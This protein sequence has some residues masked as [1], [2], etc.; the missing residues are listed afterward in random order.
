MILV[1]T[2]VG[3]MSTA[4]KPGLCSVVKEQTVS[5]CVTYVIA[6]LR[7]HHDL[8]YRIF[9][10]VGDHLEFQKMQSPDFMFE[11]Y[12]PINCPKSNQQSQQSI[13]INQSDGFCNVCFNNMLK[14]QL[15]MRTYLI[16]RQNFWSAA[17]QNIS[18]TAL[19]NF[20]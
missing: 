7:C 20:I 9:W 5:N 18:C 11:L 2:N 1:F 16:W 6:L 8:C 12:S 10:G 13:L 14:N 19:V 4:K 15:G 3:K 17:M